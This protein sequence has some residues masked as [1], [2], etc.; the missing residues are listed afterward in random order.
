MLQFLPGREGTRRKHL[1]WVKHFKSPLEWAT[2]SH[3]REPGIVKHFL[4]PGLFHPTY[5]QTAY[6]RH[7]LPS[8]CGVLLGRR[9]E[10]TPC[11]ANDLG[12]ELALFSWPRLSAYPATW[13]RWVLPEGYAPG[14]RWLLV[15]NVYDQ[16]IQIHLQG[17]MRTGEVLG[18]AI[19]RCF[20]RITKSSMEITE[21]AI[22]TDFPVEDSS[23]MLEVAA[24]N[25]KPAQWRSS[26]K[27]TQNFYCCFFDMRLWLETRGCQNFQQPLASLSRSHCK[28]P[29]KRKAFFQE[30]RNCWMGHRW[31]L[32][33]GQN[34]SGK[35]MSDQG[36]AGL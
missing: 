3:P 1:N 7:S 22:S 9:M 35:N 5:Q 13:S 21:K 8:G 12:A 10:A 6:V 16:L 25:V 18:S 2:T 15:C 36:L 28:K 17:A 32:T 19:I 26:R 34:S 11:K 33:T 23:L 14:V 27:Q 20:N 4:R 29:G 31:F 30:T 24:W